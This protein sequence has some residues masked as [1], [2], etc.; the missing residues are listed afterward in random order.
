MRKE[1]ENWI[2]WTSSLTFECLSI[3]LLMRFTS[4]ANIL[5]YKAFA[6]ASRVSVQGSRELFL[7]LEKW[8]GGTTGE[9][10][11]EWEMKKGLVLG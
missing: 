4:H 10:Q 8:G 11:S 5:E 7:S 1:K 3:M 2:D 6:S 9:S